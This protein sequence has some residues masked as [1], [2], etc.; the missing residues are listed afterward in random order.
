MEFL[1]R[2]F[3]HAARQLLRTPAFTVVAVLTLAL[4][5][6]ANS[7]IFTLLDQVMLRALPVPDPG[8]L[9][10]LKFNNVDEGN[11]RSQMDGSYYF[12]EPMY[13]ELAKR[14]DSL[15]GLL[16][17]ARYHAAVNWH[18]QT[19]EVDSELVSGNYFQV[20][21]V[22][23]ALGRLILPAD[24]EQK[25][26]SPV[27]VLSYAFWQQHFGGARNVVGQTLSVN[28]HPFT[29]IG[30][31]APGFRS[32]VVGEAPAIFMPIR[33]QPQAMPGF[34][35]LD[36]WR[37]RWLNLV[38]RLKDGVSLQQ[39][40]AQLGP[41]WHALREDD[42]QRL[43]AGHHGTDKMRQEFLASPLKLE[44][45]QKGLSPLRNDLGA[46]LTVLMGMVGLV[47]LIACANIATLLL[48]RGAARQR[49]ISI[50]FALGAPRLRVLRQLLSESLLVGVVGG[51][52]GLLIAPWATTL[53]L[54]V[55]PA[56]AEITSALSAE[57]DVRVLVFTFVVAFLTSILAGIAPAFRFSRPDVSLAMNEQSGRVAGGKSQLRRLLV[58]GQIGLSVVLLV[59]AGLFTRTLLNLRNVD[60]GFTTDHV[61]TFEANAKLNGYDDTGA[62]SVYQR[63]T[64][65]LERMPG[66]TAVAASS[67][68]LL[69]Q[70]TT[71][72]NITID[73]YKPAPDEDM[74]VDRNEVSPGYMHAMGI[75]LLAGRDFTASDA[76]GATKVCIINEKMAQRYFGGAQQA[77]GHFLVFG[78]GKVTPDIQIVGVARN[79]RY[80]AV[81][82]DTPRF[83]Y[84]PYLQTKRM[85]GMAFY[86]RTSAPTDQAANEIRTAVHNVDANL[87]V[88]YLQ[89][90]PEHVKANLF[91]QRL[92]AFLSLSF[93]GL[94]A[95][96]AAIGLYG[97]LAYSVTQRTREIG[98]RIALGATRR[99]VVRL[100]LG[101]VLLLGGAAIAVA[102]PLS[103][104]L[105]SALR[106]QL[107]DISSRDPLT[108]IAVV[109][110]VAFIALLAGALPAMRASRLDPMEALRAE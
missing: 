109:L 85:N 41:V 1:L 59:A 76:E 30:I 110:V 105:S 9:V 82:E 60:L 6:G 73:S 65:E 4:G 77:L 48:A 64:S 107:Y 97:M 57:V 35:D 102:L 3:R 18:G 58:A 7:A 49:E 40:Q 44:P 89:T 33:M 23:P 74:D 68:G 91:L 39:A 10:I 47:L 53:L 108:Y 25:N 50:C 22:R 78:A 31:A 15:T 84:L 56:Q 70:D 106:S 29:I 42:L 61:L 52:V 11:L 81:K 92:V 63:I 14:S 34:S 37:S 55:V 16:A 87:P 43:I 104:A 54:S 96:L 103:I 13:R 51:G 24:D 69:D 28:S 101:D 79:T 5:I 67:V 80:A 90:M 2:D 36:E 88:Q 26:G 86:V 71:G 17:R 19:E 72:G 46:P 99:G 32:A 100:V 8:R 38:G 45:G 21:Q 75:A 94:A 66:V 12:A 93:G 27:V 95:G 62:H 98:I 20:L 83:L